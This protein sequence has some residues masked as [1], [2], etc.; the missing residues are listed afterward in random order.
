MERLKTEPKMDRG[1]LILC[2][3]ALAITSLCTGCYYDVEEDLYPMNFCDTTSTGYANSVLPIIQ[4]N[5]A[6]P[7]CH[8][9]GGSG[10][11]DFTS[12][13]GLQTQVTNGKLIQAVQQTGG[14]AFMPPNGKLTDCEIDKITVWVNGGA[15]QN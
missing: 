11:G 15:Q 4:S 13:S 9:P 3:G 12:F 5:C 2:I 1:M 14:A 8:V 7:G 6:I 10:T